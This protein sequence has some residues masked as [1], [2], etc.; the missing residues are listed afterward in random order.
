MD[1]GGYKRCLIITI[2]T[3]TT[4]RN[5]ALANVQVTDKGNIGTLAPFGCDITPGLFTGQQNRVA[6]YHATAT[7]TAAGFAPHSSVKYSHNG[8]ATGS[9]SWGVENMG[10]AS[11]GRF[12]FHHVSSD[13]ANES[14]MTWDGQSNILVVKDIVTTGGLTVSGNLSANVANIGTGGFASTGPAIISNANPVVRLAPTSAKTAF[15]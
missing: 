13:G 1:K 4:I 15:L 2:Q 9:Y 14:K 6:G 12:A 10:A 3:T 8:G 5:L 7:S 11:P